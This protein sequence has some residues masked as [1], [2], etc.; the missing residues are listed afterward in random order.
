MHDKIIFARAKIEDAEDI[1]DI[2]Q[3]TVAE[4]YPKYYPPEV[5]D[6]FRKLHGCQNI[7]GDI[8]KGRV[9]VLRDNGIIVGTGSYE[10]QHITRVY[11]LP[12][13]QG[14]GYGGYILKEL[15][16]EIAHRHSRVFLDASLPACKFYESKGY[17]AVR[18][19]EVKCEKETVLVYDVME[20]MVAGIYN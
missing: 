16:K 3:K 4:I 15:E 20:K 2:V 14:R 7:A 17:K 9:Y 10:K 19:E 13:Y 8:Q 1:A 6:F 5:A 12:R 18:H 11:V